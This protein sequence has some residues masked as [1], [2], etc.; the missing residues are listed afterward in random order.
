[1]SKR[2]ASIALL[3]LGVSFLAMAAIGGNIFLAL[4]G[5]G[6]LVNAA[7]YFFGFRDRANE[8][9]QARL[10]AKYGGRPIPAQPDDLPHWFS[11]D[12]PPGWYLNPASGE[13]AYW[14]ELGWRRPVSR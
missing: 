8:R 2:G 7:L 6:Y 13:P 4:V 14:S 1:M 10:E 5:V 12:N 9:R 3:L 11:P